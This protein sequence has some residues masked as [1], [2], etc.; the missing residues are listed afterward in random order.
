M[1][2]DIVEESTNPGYKDEEEEDKKEEKN[3]E[4]EYLIIKKSKKKKKINL[5]RQNY[6]GDRNFVS[7]EIRKEQIER[8]KE[9]NSHIEQFKKENKDLQSTKMMLKKK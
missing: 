2:T 8:F 4:G 5:Y 1:N 6:D 3:L 7:T 9:L